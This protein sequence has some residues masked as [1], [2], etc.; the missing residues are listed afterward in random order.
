ML[1]SSDPGR[2]RQFCATFSLV[3]GKYGRSYARLTSVY[4]RIRQFTT[5]YDRIRQ[6]TSGCGGIRLCVGG[7]TS[8]KYGSHKRVRRRR[9]LPLLLLFSTRI[10]LVLVT[11]ELPDNG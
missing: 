5:V 11:L 4:D 6:D 3:Y 1:I 7:G 8:F 9:H 10:V 2:L